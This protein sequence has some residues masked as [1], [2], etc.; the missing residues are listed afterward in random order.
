[1]ITSNDVLIRSGRRC[2][3]CFGLDQDS[4]QKEGQIT[5]VDRDPQN[6]EFE[7]LAYLCLDHHNK[8]DS[9]Y[10]QS[11]GYTLGELL[12]YRQ[13]LYEHVEGCAVCQSR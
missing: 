2:A 5:H 4:S 9:K 6:N 1:M 3:F 8:Y 12:H 13:N 11:R 10:S 7:N